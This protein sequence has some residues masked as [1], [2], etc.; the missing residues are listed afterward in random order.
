M[1]TTVQPAVESDFKE[2]YDQYNR[3]IFSRLVGHGIDREEARELVSK[4][5]LQAY[6]GWESFRG[7]SSV[8][9]WLI[10]ITDRVALNHFRDRGR[11]KN[12]GFVVSIDDRQPSESGQP[13]SETLETS[14]PESS[15]LERLIKQEKVRILWGAL[16]Q[17]PPQMRQVTLLRIRNELTYQEIADT[18]RV[19]LNTVRSQLH[20]ARRRLRKALQAQYDDVEF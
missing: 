18:L 16:T 6:R 12:K 8:K 20:E 11:L 19:S 13:L 9:T 7:D 10:T 5:F 1:T 3:L 14:G 17:L 2:I 4:T 15:P